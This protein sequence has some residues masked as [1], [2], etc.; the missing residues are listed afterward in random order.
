MSKKVHKKVGALLLLAV[1]LTT[2]FIQKPVVAEAVTPSKTNYT[3]SLKDNG[4]MYMHNKKTI[5]SE[6]GTEYFMTY[7]VKDV[8]GAATQQGI[9]GSID[10]TPNFPYQKGNGMMR[11]STRGNL[12]LEKGATYFIKVTVSNGGFRYNVTKAKGDE[13]TNIYFEEMAGGAKKDMLYYGIWIAVATKEESKTTAELTNVRCYD[14]EGNDLGISI[15]SDGASVVTGGSAVKPNSNLNHYYEIYVDKKNQIA[16]SN[17]KPSDSET[18]Y[19]EYEVEEAEYNLS[20]EGVAMS[21]NY[22]A[23]YPHGKGQLRYFDYAEQRDS[24]EMLQPGASYYIIVERDAEKYQVSVQ[25]VNGNQISNF[26]FQR[27]YRTYKPEYMYTSLWFSNE[28]DV[29]QMS[30]FKLTKFK[31]YDADKKDLG[32]QTNRE[33][34]IIR[35]GALDNYEDCSATYYCQENG[36][37]LALYDDQTIKFTKDGA[38]QQGTYDVLDNVMTANFGG[39]DTEYDYYYRKVIDKDGNVYKRLFN[40]KIKFETGKG[41]SVEAQR[42]SPKDGYVAVKPADPTLKDCEFLG[43]YTKDGEEYDFNQLVTESKTLYA[44]WS[45]EGGVVFLSE[46]NVMT[47]VLLGVSVLS[48]AAGVVACVLFIRRGVKNNGNEK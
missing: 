32:V 36:N 12:L 16:I 10:P 37:S 18:V 39:E 31:M 24:V 21:N 4:R 38:T 23:A 33:S 45:G 1:M 5:G 47:Y 14:A 46:S 27:A 3:V 26:V 13:L 7:T 28:N 2:T 9:M 6:I 48:L 17:S 11:H 30:S 44:K 8:K 42:F 34:V 29:E 35:R 40:Y 15:G 19:I 25:R 22:K 43:W 41:S 20:Q